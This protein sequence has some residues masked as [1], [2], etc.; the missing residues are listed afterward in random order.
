MSSTPSVPPLPQG[1]L[2]SKKTKII[3]TLGPASFEKKTLRALILAG[4]NVMRLNFSHADY[5]L[6][7]QAIQDIRDLNSELGTSVGI[8]GDLQGPKI[9]IGEMP[10]GGILFEPGD[11]LTMVTNPV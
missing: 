11:R 10:Q 5:S 3:T 9:R 2:A 1:S 7:T 8:L 6:L 4:A